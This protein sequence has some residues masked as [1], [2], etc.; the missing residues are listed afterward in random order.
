MASFDT[1]PIVSSLLQP[2]GGA[3]DLGD[4][5]VVEL[6]VRGYVD[7]CLGSFREAA[8]GRVSQDEAV[9]GIYQLAGALN[10]VFLGTSGFHTLTVHPWNAPDQLGVFL[11]D[12]LDLDFPP[13]ECV[14]AALVH[15]A[16]QIMLGVQQPQPEW[17]GMIEDLSVEMRDLLLGRAPAGDGEALPYA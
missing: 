7:R 12:T 3:N 13:D 10:A 4:E 6:L 17:E 2:L 11:R 5:R 14:R 16:T 8:E 9:D 15:L 1:Q